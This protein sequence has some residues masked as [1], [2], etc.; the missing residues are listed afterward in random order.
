MQIAHFADELN[1][2]MQSDKKPEFLEG[3]CKFLSNTIETFSANLLDDIL[4][5]PRAFK[6]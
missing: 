1:A 3:L 5:C 6:D 2:F 4:E